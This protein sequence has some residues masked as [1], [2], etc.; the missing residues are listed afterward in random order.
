LESNFVSFVLFVSITLVAIIQTKFSNNIKHSITRKE[1]FLDHEKIICFTFYR[2][3]S[4]L[5]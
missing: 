4:F 2:G 3:N 5:R 1:E